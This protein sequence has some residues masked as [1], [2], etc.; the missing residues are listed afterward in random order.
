M[1][2]IGTRI[3]TN[4]GWVNIEKLKVG[5]KVVSCDGE[6]VLYKPIEAIYPDGEFYDLTI[7]DTHNF[8][9]HNK[10]E[11]TIQ[12]APTTPAPSVGE[13]SADLYKAKLQ[14]DPLTAAQEFQTQSQYQPLMA[15]LQT[16]I[17]QQ[18]SPGLAQLYTDVQ[19]TQM[20]QLQ[21]LQADLFPQQS[22]V[23]EAGAGDVLQRLQSDFGYTQEE[24]SALGGLRQRQREAL[25]EALRTR[26]NLGG[27]L[28]GG[29]AAETEQKGLTGLEQSFADE[30]INRKLQAGQFAQQAAIPYM[31][32]LYPQVGMPQMQQQTFQSQGV[33]PSADTLYNALFQ[34]SQP[35]SFQAKNTGGVSLGLLGQFGMY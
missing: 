32:I 29:R 9:V 15:A 4:N 14:Y 7:S 18:Q 17:A 20:P 12:Q 26:A 33:T 5:D 30:D 21:Q 34:A 23:I 10:G 19:K 24:E 27:G 25:V 8:I 11:T 22:K 1:F 6:K 31:Q 28:Y 3:L 16:Q 2:K 13:S 35:Q